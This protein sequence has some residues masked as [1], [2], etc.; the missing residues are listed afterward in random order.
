[1][2]PLTA[3]PLKERGHLV[4]AMTYPRYLTSASKLAESGPKGLI[5]YF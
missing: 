2:V 5:L 3:P 1:M 4:A